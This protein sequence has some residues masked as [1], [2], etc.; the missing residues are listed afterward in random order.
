[1]RTPSG[2]LRAGIGLGGGEMEIEAAGQAI[3]RVGR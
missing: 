3:F 1:M 2:V